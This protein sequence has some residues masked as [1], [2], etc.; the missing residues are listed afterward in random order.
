ML[1]QKQNTISN[2]RDFT[3]NIKFYNM[4]WGMLH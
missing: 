2:F 3:P 4:T 1:K